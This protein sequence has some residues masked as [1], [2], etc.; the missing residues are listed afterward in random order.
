M[1]VDVNLTGRRIGVLLNTS[2]GG[3]DAEAEHDLIAAL[4]SFG[5]TPVRTW[6]GGGQEVE[7]ALT[8]ARDHQL[9]VLV[10]LGG[11]G[12]IRAAAEQC[13]H[14]GPILMPLPGGT[15][16]MLPKAL[17]GDRSWRDALRDTLQAPML[18][19]VHGGQVGDRRFFIAAI[20]GGPTRLAQAREA[21]R[22]GQITEAV[23]KGV[24]ALK[25]ALSDKLAYSFGSR[26]GEAEAVAVLCPLTSRTLDAEEEVLEAAAIQVEGTVD[27]LRLSLNAA[28]RD[29]R[30]D[31]GVDRAK[32]SRMQ[33]RADRPIPALLDGETFQMARQIEVHL[34]KA[35]LQVMRPRDHS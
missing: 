1:T 22:D 33:L 12:T 31:P 32:L 28:F 5:L 20:F 23:A 25:D 18:Q 10:V 3:C 2:S 6:C 9:D 24:D 30:E 8:E 34:V 26:L 19:P 14:E 13:G 27:A 16:N 35:A 17:Y 11:D 21:I 15:M 7:S 29:W 4:E